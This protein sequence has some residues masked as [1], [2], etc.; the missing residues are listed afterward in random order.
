MVF[1]KP[2][3]QLFNL[4]IWPLSSK[5]DNSK[6]MAISPFTYS[7]YTLIV[8][9]NFIE[10]ELLVKFKSVCSSAILWPSFPKCDNFLFHTYL[11]LFLLRSFSI[12][13]WSKKHWERCT[14]VHIVPVSCP[15]ALTK[16][17]LYTLHQVS[18]ETD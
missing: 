18:A 13:R 17:T 3:E 1:I 11:A 4:I 14:A 6:D 7:A 2:E 12:F 16:L 10:T 15:K 9:E 8:T 5:T